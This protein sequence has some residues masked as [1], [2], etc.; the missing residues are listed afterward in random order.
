MK[1]EW[2]PEATA[3]KILPPRCFPS[4]IPTFHINEKWIMRKSFGRLMMNVQP[5]EP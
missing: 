5:V 2:P 3:Q 1:N 4:A